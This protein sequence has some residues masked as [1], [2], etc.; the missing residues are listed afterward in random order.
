MT[1]CP[2]GRKSPQK[3][4]NPPGHRNYRAEPEIEVYLSFGDDKTMSTL[5]QAIIIAAKAHMNQTD[6]AGV[7]Y[8]LHP[9]RL[10]LN[11][12]TVEEQ[13]TAVLHD[14]IE[15]SP[16]TLE[17]L[18]TAGFSVN[19]LEAVRILTRLKD[20]SYH[21]YLKGIAGND[22]AKRVKLLDLADNMN[23]ERIKNPTKEDFLRLEKYEKALKFLNE[24]KNDG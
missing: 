8:I 11:A 12:K 4:L 2:G 10:M 16:I 15:D 17:E 20:T 18:Q 13:I 1:L 6:K 9:L 5:E 22:L 14:V 3:N 23:L 24:T 19:V 7:P 21:Q